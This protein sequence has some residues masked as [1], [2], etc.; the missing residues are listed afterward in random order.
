[1]GTTSKKKVAHYVKLEN[2][3][4]SGK[5]TDPKLRPRNLTFDEKFP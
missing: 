1:M 5:K 2:Q 4:K 3:L